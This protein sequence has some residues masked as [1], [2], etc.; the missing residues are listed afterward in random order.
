MN[1]F[2]TL[3]RQCFDPLKMK[4]VDDSRIG[5]NRRNFFPMIKIYFCRKQLKEEFIRIDERRF[6]R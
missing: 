3:F 4:L 5:C 1:V 2:D 6:E